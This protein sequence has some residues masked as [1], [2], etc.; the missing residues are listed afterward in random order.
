LFPLQT[1][2]KTYRINMSQELVVPCYYYFT[3]LQMEIQS[4]FETLVNIYHT[5]SVISQNTAMVAVGK[6]ELS[7]VD[8]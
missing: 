4:F 3:T 6:V 7:E 5:Y 1:E 2:G 8:T